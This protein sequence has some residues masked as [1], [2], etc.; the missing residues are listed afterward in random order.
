MV[1]TLWLNLDFPFPRC[2]ILGNPLLATLSSA[3]QCLGFLGREKHPVP[4]LQVHICKSRGQ[5][6]FL[7]MGFAHC[8]P[9]RILV[10]SFP[11]KHGEMRCAGLISSEGQEKPLKASPKGPPYPAVWHRFASE[12]LCNLSLLCS[13]CD[14]MKAF[15]STVIE[16]L[17]SSEKQSTIPSEMVFE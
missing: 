7:S 9:H 8:M 4:H 10:V 2:R 15:F 13:M 5:W 11:Q 6:I 16:L 1:T 12:E 14:L 3:M 17:I